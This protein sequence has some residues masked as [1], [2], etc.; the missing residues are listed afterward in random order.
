MVKIIVKIFYHY[1]NIDIVLYHEDLK[2]P[3]SA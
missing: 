1:G 3:I 2:V